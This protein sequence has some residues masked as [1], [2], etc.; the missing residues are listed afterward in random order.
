MKGM[1]EVRQEIIHLGGGWD[2]LTPT[3][4]LKPGVVR[5]SLNFEANATN[6]YTRIAG[7]ERFDGQPAPSAATY[8]MVFVDAMAY[9]PVVG[10]TITGSISGATGV[11]IATGIVAGGDYIAY[12]KATGDF[13]IATPDVISVG[14]SVVGNAVVPTGSV[15]SETYATYI[16]L[17][18]DAYRSD[19]LPVPGSGAALGYVL[20]NDVVYAFRANAGATAVDLYKSSAAGWVNV[21]FY[22]EVFFS[23][24]SDFPAEGA[25]ITQGGVTATVKRVVLQS[26]AYA[27]GTAAGK[28]IITTP[29]GGSFAAGAFTA[30][31]TATCAGAETAISFAVGGKFEFAYG[32][33]YGGAATNRVYGCD[34]VNRMFEF[35]G[36]VLVPIDTGFPTDAPKHIEIHKTYLFA[37]FGASLGYS[38]PG[39]PYDWTAISGA[40]EIG[41]GQDITGLKV[42]PGSASAPALLVTSRT[43]TYILYGSSA[44]VDFNFVSYNSG[45]GALDY[46]IQNMADTYLMDDRGVV[47]LQT[48]LNFGN[49]DQ[50]TLTYQ[51]NN[52]IAQHR[53]MLSYTT[54]DRRKSQYRLFF[55]DGYGLYVTIANKQ[56][57]GAMAVYFPNAVYMCDESRYSDGEEASFFCSTDG[58]VYQLDKGTSFDGAP[59]NEYLTLTYNPSGSPRTR[60][61]YRKAAVEMSGSGFCQINFG[62][63]L[64]YSKDEISQPD[65][66][67]YASYIGS[68]Q[69]D[70]FTWDSFTWDGVSVIPSECEMVGT[71]ENVAITIRSGSP[72]YQPYTVNSIIMHYTARRA[73]R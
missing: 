14:A 54:L 56:M 64:G 6:G 5:D 11:V 33:F 12:T 32:N 57:K 30:G 49:F 27:G 29:S 59:L 15:D 24:A 51:I 28:L 45:A 20:Y 44:S 70:N 42:L 23:S 62:Y 67:N 9:T 58:Y 53:T 19:I 63:A 22:S 55:S 41:V 38:A 52:F 37:S 8:S 31:M 68:M 47:S 35:D 26:G 25:T 50:S 69:W 36:D 65:S 34:G 21:P 18:A 3:L 72:Y 17:A 40:G 10:D 39:L 60:K 1:P 16:G 66:A 43:N 73:L 2:Q 48:S 7:Y 13:D 46:S 71:A 4:L 61:R